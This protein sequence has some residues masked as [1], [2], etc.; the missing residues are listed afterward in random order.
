MAT[1]LNAPQKT[2]V[3]V[4]DRRTEDIG[5]IVEFGHVNFQVADQQQAIVFYVMGLGLTRDPYLVTGVDNAWI[6]AGTCQFHL[7]VGKA[8]VLRGV[9][10]LVM[11]DLD[12]L[13][14][15]LE[16]VR[17]RLE[18]TAFSFERHGTQ[19]D[20][21]CPWGNRLRVHAPDQARFG[22]V[23]LGMP[24]VE[25]DVPVGTAAGIARFYADVMASQALVD[26][27]AEGSFTRVPIGFAEGLLFRETTRTLPAYDGYHI[28]IAVA[29]FSGV[30][31]RL[32][33][34]GLITE[35]SNQSQYR[36]QD[37]VDPQSGQVLTTLE[38]EVRSM[39]HPM[40]ARRLVNR[41]AAVTSNDYATGY[42][43]A[44]WRMP[45]G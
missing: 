5:N 28:Q 38:H 8:Q 1:A 13:A 26:Q 2:V 17:P 19:V 22:P 36:F 41:D 23:I 4:Y 37:I 18:G 43:V 40:Y 9:V 39:R 16:R 6:N 42:E 29:D 44:M 3:P 34:R 32:L 7:P 25:L 12:A 11:P 31:L 35:E 30:H 21:T 15:R 10:G 14:V 27:D 24:Y 33:E 20:V 45:P